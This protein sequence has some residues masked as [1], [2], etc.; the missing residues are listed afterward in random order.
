MNLD[1]RE[2]HP[3]T[4]PT[5]R[6]NHCKRS[7]KRGIRQQPWAMGAGAPNTFSMFASL[8]QGGM[9]VQGGCHTLTS[10]CCSEKAA[11]HLFLNNFSQQHIKLPYPISAS[12]EES[13]Q[14][15]TSHLHLPVPSRGKFFPNSCINPPGVRSA[16]PYWGLG[17]KQAACSQSP[18]HALPELEGR[19]PEAG[20]AQPHYSSWQVPD[21][22]WQ[23]SNFGVSY[24]GFYPGKRTKINHCPSNRILH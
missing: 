12:S 9:I 8:T 3:S 17:Q 2:T 10:K 5:H 1:H 15:T 4:H 18:S 24:Y 19:Q 21:S 22:Y 11:L 14:L 6:N 7:N 16:Y 13:K 20:Q 23:H